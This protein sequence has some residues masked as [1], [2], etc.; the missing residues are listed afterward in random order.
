MSAN[1]NPDTSPGREID[2]S[3]RLLL[4][5]PLYEPKLTGEVLDFKQAVKIRGHNRWHENLLDF[6]Y[7]HRQ[8]T[9]YG[10]TLA[11]TGLVALVTCKVIG[12]QNTADAQALAN[13]HAQQTAVALEYEKSSR[14][15]EEDK[16]FVVAP[17]TTSTPTSTQSPTLIFT[18]TKV[19]ETATAKP[20]E[21]P[22]SIATPTKVALQEVKII[23]QEDF[24]KYFQP[25]TLKDLLRLSEEQNKDIIPILFSKLP[26]KLEY[27]K[28]NDWM[29]LAEPPFTVIA[30]YLGQYN[31]AGSNTY[32]KM[33]NYQQPLE[34]NPPFHVKKVRF[35]TSSQAQI[36]T[37]QKP[38]KLVKKGEK[39]AIF[40][41]LPPFKD[42]DGNPFPA[43]R[44]S[45]AF[46]D[47]FY[48][49]GIFPKDTPQNNLSSLTT[50][51]NGRV[52]MAF[53]DEFFAG[54]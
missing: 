17:T 14:Q 3:A 20:T 53:A 16:M 7:Q 34:P 9:E 25:V 19:P 32:F 47:L 43:N 12:D 18:P 10:L 13:I 52:A 4:A 26:D 1:P 50:T 11:F 42:A 27:T 36:D 38:N 5:K 31:P 41:T 39:I 28:Y 22:T 8:A 30:P 51:D 23:E 49:G 48:S 45:F 37:L 2:Q 44:V 40:K 6:L 15:A 33:I 35:L 24:Y 54:K 29:V 21:A 46:S